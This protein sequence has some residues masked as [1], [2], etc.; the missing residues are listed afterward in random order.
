MV[1]GGGGGKGAGKTGMYFAAG[2]SDWLRTCEVEVGVA[3]LPI[4]SE[5]PPD[6]QVHLETLHSVLQQSLAVTDLPP[7]TYA[8]LGTEPSIVQELLGGKIW[9]GFYPEAYLGGRKLG[10]HSIVPAKL[11]EVIAAAIQ[12]QGAKHGAIQASTQQYAE[13]ADSVTL[14]RKA[15]AD[16]ASDQVSKRPCTAAAAAAIATAAAEHGP[17]KN[18][19][20][21]GEICRR[22]RVFRVA[23]SR[24]LLQRPGS[25]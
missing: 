22:S 24:R 14:A 4:F 20:R 1:P 25:S 9:A 11:L 21:Q 18:C 16:F 6:W 17:S 8:Q 7:L 12:I 19:W 5:I 3:D 15:A 2:Q 13:A 10:G 23:L